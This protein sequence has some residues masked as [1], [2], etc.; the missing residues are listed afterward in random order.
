MFASNIE[1][2]WDLISSGWNHFPCLTKPSA[3][4][5]I[6]DIV[7]MAIGAIGVSPSI[8]ATLKWFSNLIYRPYIVLWL[9]SQRHPSMN[10]LAV[11]TRRMTC[12]YMWTEL[13]KADT[14]G[15]GEEPYSEEGVVCL[16]SNSPL[17]IQH[18]DWNPWPYYL[19]L[20]SLI[21]TPH[22]SRTFFRKGLHI[23]ELPQYT[24]P[25]ERKRV[26]TLERCTQPFGGWE[27]IHQQ[28]TF[29]WLP[30]SWAACHNMLS[31]CYMGASWGQGR[32]PNDWTESIHE[33]GGVWIGE[34]KLWM[35][36]HSWG[37]GAGEFVFCLSPTC[38]VCQATKPHVNN[39]DFEKERETRDSTV[40]K[41]SHL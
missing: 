31:G 30:S 25:S 27:A 7:N 11:T 18:F 35:V 15:E 38:L 5:P 33:F 17:E 1:G 6:K 12:T 24:K 34:P 36:F 9:V 23:R 29:S 3:V 19:T 13:K 28:T 21:R 41:H 39:T 20:Y 37:T 8:W 32:Q 10:K 14:R 26:K 4:R 40:C 16:Y 22:L 2:F